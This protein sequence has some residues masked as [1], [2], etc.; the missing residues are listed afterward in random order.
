MPRNE[1]ETRAELIDPLLAAAGWGSVDG[2]RVMREA[3]IT[4]GRL[5][6]AGQRGLPEIADYILV[7][8][9]TKLAVIEAKAENLPTS[10]GVAQAKFY[11]E[12]LAVR[13]AYATNGHDI[14]RMDLVGGAEGG[15]PSF[16]APDELWNFTFAAQ[17][18]WRDRFT[19]SL[20]DT[21]LNLPISLSS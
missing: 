11:A 1:S 15:V 4:K 16:P 12:K 8:R 6:G 20:P 10:E 17:N 7:Y 5:M 13:I 9:N 19:A 18:E 14:Y 3:R 2:S 21:L